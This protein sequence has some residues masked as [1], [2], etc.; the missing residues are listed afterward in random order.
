MEICLRGV[1]L[2]YG[3]KKIV[4]NISLCF[5]PGLTYL[6]GKN[7][8]GK[9][10]LLKSLCGILPYSGT[11]LLD[12]QSTHLFHRKELASKI[13][14]LKQAPT[15]SFRMKVLEYV[16][17]GRYAYTNFW[18]SYSKDDRIIASQSLEKIGIKYLSQAYLNEISGGEFQ[19][20]AIARALCQ[21]A[22]TILLD[23]PTQ[24]LDPKARLQVHEL[25]QKMG[26]QGKTIICVTHDI[27]RLEDE[28]VLVVGL[29][30]GEIAFQMRG[31][32]GLASLLL[33]EIY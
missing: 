29:K 12:N 30:Q 31:K 8:S 21:R 22:E 1:S 23:E 25:L 9:S 15:F 27:D 18:K 5:Y 6:V 32:P 7:G 19:K 17:M 26:K 3:D 14:Y 10:T 11:I 16:L 13:V 28:K 24:A 20:V 4:N 33:E 2:A